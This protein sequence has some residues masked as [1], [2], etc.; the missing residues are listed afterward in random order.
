[1]IRA[2]GEPDAAQIAELWSTLIRETTITFNS[3]EKTAADIRTLLAEKAEAACPFFVAVEGDTVLGFAT[4][5]P[6]RNGPGYART[7]E[8][9]IMLDDRA[10]G[11]GHGRGLMRA[12]EDH[13]RARDMHTIWAGVS[14]ENPAGVTFHRHLGFDQIATLPQVGYKFGRWLDLVLL[15]KRL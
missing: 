14:G 12:L 5:G 1:M 8:H 3:Q 13:A 4:Y 7:I 10:R 9:S 6:F 2:A 15:C 11:R